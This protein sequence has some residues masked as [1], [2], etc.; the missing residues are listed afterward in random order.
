M[1]LFELYLLTRLDIIHE[2][3]I[4]ATFLSCFLLLFGLIFGWLDNDEDF[5]C[6]KTYSVWRKRTGITLV[7]SSVLLI[8]TPTTKDIAIIYG[9]NYA[10]NSE[11]VKKLPDNIL[12]TIN[13]QLEEWQ[14]Q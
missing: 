10:T 13:T 11:E 4:V 2:T 3:L 5:A 12:K 6:P 8:A 1:S 14:E 9:L 7:I